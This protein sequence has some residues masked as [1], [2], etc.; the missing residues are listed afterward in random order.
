MA[1]GKGRER[2]ERDKGQA[3]LAALA[4]AQSVGQKQ[5]DAG[6]ERGASHNHEQE[7]GQREIDSFHFWPPRLFPAIRPPVPPRKSEVDPI[8]GK[9]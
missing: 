5:P 7:L 4:A 3:D 6:G 8:R 1:A 2:A 9:A